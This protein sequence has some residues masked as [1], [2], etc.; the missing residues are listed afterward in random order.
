MAKTFIIIRNKAEAFPPLWEIVREADGW[1]TLYPLSR[2]QVD[3]FIHAR[4]MAQNATRIVFV[5]CSPHPQ[6][7]E[8]LLQLAEASIDY[9]T[10]AELRADVTAIAVEIKN[11][12]RDKRQEDQVICLLGSM[13][14]FDYA[15]DLEE[16]NLV[17]GPGDQQMQQVG[18]KKV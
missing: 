1:N 7:E 8:R 14:G 5:A 2:D 11:L 6:V 17:V 15:E 9:W 18:K 3:V 16:N 4:I 13:A 10:L 12:W